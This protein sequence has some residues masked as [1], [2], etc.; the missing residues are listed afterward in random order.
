[1]NTNKLLKIYQTYSLEKIS[2]LSKKG[3]AMQYAQCEQLVSLKKELASNTSVVNKIL[4]NQIKELERQEKVRYYK[5]LIFNINLTV[6][7]IEN[8]Q[9]ANL[10]IFLSS[11]FLSPV[12]LYANESI[13]NLEDI[14]DK[15]Y[16]HN[17]L[18]RT[19]NLKSLIATEGS[20]YKE[21]C[22]AKYLEAK[23]A[24]DDK[25]QDKTII[26]KEKEIRILKQEQQENNEKYKNKR[27]V[28]IGCL[29]C[30]GLFTL[31]ILITLIVSF[32]DN[33]PNKMGGVYVVSIAMAITAFVYSWNKKVNKEGKININ[34]IHDKTESLITQLQNEITMLNAQ[35]EEINTH[36]SNIV[37]SMNEECNNWEQ[38]MSELLQLLPHDLDSGNQSS[39]QYDPLLQEVA[40]FVVAS[41]SVSIS[42]IQRRFSIGF[43]RAD[44]IMDQL[45]TIG[46][47]GPSQ[48]GSQRKVIC[49]YSYVDNLNTILGQT[50]S[51]IQEK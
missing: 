11:L 36:Y 4:R 41:Q 32:I 38:Q 30:S 14:A 8:V 42:S 16:A 12:I 17:A 19:D 37:N 49:N 48:G 33:D 39:I 31:F 25:A 27:T 20:H 18:K 21:T 3:L 46:V 40:S 47:V 1:M 26:Q 29:G 10:K 5:N 34:Q 35:K 9:N 24:F 45:E 51:N 15:E 28:S 43:N 2:A 22:W 44:K 6:E 23:E 50:L 13:Q 7:R